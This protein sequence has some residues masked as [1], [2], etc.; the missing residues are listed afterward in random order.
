[1]E[2]Y[3]I[4][5]LLKNSIVLKF[6]TKKWIQLT[7]LSNGQCSADKNVKFKTPMLRSDLR[8]Y[9][10]AFKHRSHQSIQIS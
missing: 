5:K 3:K 1:M 7:D 2:Q 4:Y 9:S 6:V 10:D 8:D